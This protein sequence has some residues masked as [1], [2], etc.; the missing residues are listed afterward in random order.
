MVILALS[1]ALALLPLAGI[2]A[3]F[4]QGFL[5]TVGGLFMTLILLAISA[6]F[7]LNVASE[8]RR[9]KKSKAGPP[10]RA[11]H[12]VAGQKGS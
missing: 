1:L 12:A 3:I 10:V 11:A 7:L 6:I 8:V 2:A 9:W 4:A 5:T